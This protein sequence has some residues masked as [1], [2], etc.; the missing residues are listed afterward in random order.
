MLCIYTTEALV[1]ALVADVTTVVQ[2]TVVRGY[3]RLEREI[4][5]DMAADVL[6]LVA[7]ETILSFG[8]KVACTLRQQHGGR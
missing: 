4:A 1:N 7:A 2:L 3:S 8:G 6:S 5:T